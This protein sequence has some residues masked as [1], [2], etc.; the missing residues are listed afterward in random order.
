MKET[1]YKTHKFFG[2]LIFRCGIQLLITF[3]TIQNESFTSHYIQKHNDILHLYNILIHDASML[4]LSVALQFLWLQYIFR[5]VIFNIQRLSSSHSPMKHHPQDSRTNFAFIKMF[6]FPGLLH[7]VRR[8]CVYSLKICCEFH[9]YFL[10][11]MCF[12]L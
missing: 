9:S 8:K 6:V 4:L 1:P 12:I 3:I 7:F 2:V 10:D 5:Y 11:F